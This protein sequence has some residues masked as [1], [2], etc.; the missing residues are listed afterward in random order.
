MSRIV[1]FVCLDDNIFRVCCFFNSACY[2]ILRDISTVLRGPLTLMQY[3]YLRI[4]YSHV[5]LSKSELQ[6]TV[7]ASGM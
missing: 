1:L 6:P 4:Y 7:M 2:N 5:L 3:S